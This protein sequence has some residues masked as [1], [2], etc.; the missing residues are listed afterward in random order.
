M[1]INTTRYKVIAFVIGAFFAGIAGGLYAHS[2]QYLTPEGFTFK[3][4]I[5]IVVMVILG[6]MG[7]NRRRHR[8]GGVA[9]RLARSAAHVSDITWLPQFVR[10]LTKNRMILLLAAPDRPDAAAPAGPL[11]EPWT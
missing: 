6:G 1:G 5:E 8:R 11:F 10:D 9:D 2:K 4:T 3:K 7:N